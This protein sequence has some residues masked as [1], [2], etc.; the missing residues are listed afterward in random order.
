MLDAI[1]NRIFRFEFIYISNKFKN[2]SFELILQL[3][4][5]LN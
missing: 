2:E 5:I 1:L 3:K 4:I